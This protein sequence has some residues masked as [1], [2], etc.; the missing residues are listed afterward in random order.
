MSTAPDIWRSHLQPDERL[1]WSISASPDLVR[2][3]ASRQR[4]K[5]LTILA[6]A[7]LGA[8]VLAIRFVESIAPKPPASSFY[9]ISN[10]DFDPFLA[11]LYLAGA[12]SLGVV[13]AFAAFRLIKPR[14]PIAFD[15][16][17]T[18]RRLLALGPDGRIAAQMEGAS[19]SGVTIYESDRE[20]SIV[21][22][23]RDDGA[24][25][26]FAMTFIAAPR[27]AKAIIEETFPALSASTM[28]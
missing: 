13:A 3:D 2:S 8:T 12:I 26:R 23:P 6:V 16:A 10:L 22:H 19:I 15:F 1:V 18:N 7:G 27:E 17:V 20:S 14:W 9:V 24:G 4:Q 21:A 5:S 11:P 28:Q 25:S